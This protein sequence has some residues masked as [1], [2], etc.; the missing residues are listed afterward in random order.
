M[1]AMGWSDGDDGDGDDGVVMEG[2]ESEMNECR[3]GPNLVYQK[4]FNFNFLLF[5]GANA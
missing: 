4:N 2:G 5:V 1:G 3:T